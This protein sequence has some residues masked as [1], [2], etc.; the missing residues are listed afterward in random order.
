M[1]AEILL[2]KLGNPEKDLKVIHIAGT[3]GKGSVC[4]MLSSILKEAGY[5]VGMYTSPHL[6]D[7]RERFLINNKKISI[8]IEYYPQ[9]TYLAFR[10]FSSYISK[11]N[12]KIMKKLLYLNSEN[13]SGTIGLQQ[14]KDK[15]IV[16]IDNSL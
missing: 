11:L 15:Y 13:I 14:V 4:A 7:F 12:V 8:L 2:K 10:S 5:K 9:Y 3:N 16:T 1:S 6:K